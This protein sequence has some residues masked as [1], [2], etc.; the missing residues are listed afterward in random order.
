MKTKPTSIAP[1]NT[2][3]HRRQHTQQQQQQQWHGNQQV[4][5]YWSSPV[6]LLRLALVRPATF[7]MFNSMILSCPLHAPLVESRNYHHYLR[8]RQLFIIRTPKSSITQPSSGCFSRTPAQRSAFSDHVLDVSLYFVLVGLVWFV[9]DETIQTKNVQN[10]FFFSCPQKY[11]QNPNQ[12]NFKHHVGWHF[13]FAIVSF[14]RYFSRLK[15]KIAKGVKKTTSATAVCVGVSP[16][17]GLPPPSPPPFQS[18][19]AAHSVLP[20]VW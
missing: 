13:C 7:S 20:P 11:I 14:R 17:R 4:E 3:Q 19:P 1:N 5:V 18:S 8:Q 16:V 10:H 2:H 12:P 9:D 15:K 6:L